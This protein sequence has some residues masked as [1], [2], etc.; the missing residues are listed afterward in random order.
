MGPRFELPID[1]L[2]PGDC[3]LLL[4][5]SFHPL[6]PSVCDALSSVDGAARHHLAITF[7]RGP[8]HLLDRWDGDGASRP[9][10]LAIVHAT[11]HDGPAPRSG[12]GGRAVGNGSSAGG[13]P[14]TLDASTNGQA[15]DGTDGFDD[16]T[17]ERVAAPGNLTRL[18]VAITER[19]EALADRGADGRLTVCFDSVSALLQY[20]DL[21]TAFQ[22]LHALRTQFEAADAVAHYHLDPEAHDDQAVAT[23]GELFDVVLERDGEGR[24]VRRA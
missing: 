9:S 14:A 10:S 22:F 19:L 12:P 2:E 13:E 4:C 23:L 20:V 6:E 17:V 15:A 7:T 11:G 18:G 1:R 16:V 24:V 21:E 5:P 8:R 3:V